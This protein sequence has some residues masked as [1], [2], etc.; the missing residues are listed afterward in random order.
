MLTKVTRVLLSR[1]RLRVPCGAAVPRLRSGFLGSQSRWRDTSLLICSD[2]CQSPVLVLRAP[3]EPNGTGLR[4]SRITTPART[5]F[6][7]IRQGCAGVGWH[8]R[9]HWR[10]RGVDLCLLQGGPV[11]TRHVEPLGHFPLWA[12]DCGLSRARIIETAKAQLHQ[13]VDGCNYAARLGV[14]E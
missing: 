10:T 13:T 1:C 3:R 7:T 14:Y 4:E 9:L 6:S 8:K 5:C 11:L 2:L 12:A